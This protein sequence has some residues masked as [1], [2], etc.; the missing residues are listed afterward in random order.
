MDEPCKHYR[1]PHPFFPRPLGW[2]CYEC[3]AEEYAAWQ[4]SVRARLDEA[5]LHIAHGLDVTWDRL[6]CPGWPHCVPDGNLKWLPSNWTIS[7]T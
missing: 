4:A 6:P 5:L 2:R 7:R 1:A 3:E